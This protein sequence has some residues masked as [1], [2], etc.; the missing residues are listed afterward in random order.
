MIQGQQINWT[1][2]GGQPAPPPKQ[3]YREVT[4][5]RSGRRGRLVRDDGDTLLVS[6]YATG[7]EVVN[8][9]DVALSWRRP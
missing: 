2:F 1:F 8:K 3:S 6:F 9:K 4:E 5:H 7:E